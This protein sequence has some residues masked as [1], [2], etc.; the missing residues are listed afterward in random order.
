[1]RL[2]PPLSWLYAGWMAFSHILGMV[3]SK[4]ILTLLWIVG[5]GL[6]AIV[7]KAIHLIKGEPPKITYW[8]IPPE[9][10]EGRLKY[11]F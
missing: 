1:M 8:Q 4:I 7:M 5:F 9:E 6:Y 2:P 11:Q 3:M 10:F